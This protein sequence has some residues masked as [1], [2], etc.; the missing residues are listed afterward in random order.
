MTEILEGSSNMHYSQPEFILHMA[1]AQG[2]TYPAALWAFT[3]RTLY[4][5]EPQ[6]ILADI[7]FGVRDQ[8]RRSLLDL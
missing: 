5:D 6:S 1:A 3:D 4:N 7:W 8:E 2:T